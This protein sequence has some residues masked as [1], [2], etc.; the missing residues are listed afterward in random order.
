[1]YNGIGLAQTTIDRILVVRRGPVT[2][3]DTIYQV[4][5]SDTFI[6]VTDSASQTYFISAWVCSGS[7]DTYANLSVLRCDKEGKPK[8]ALSVRMSN[9]LTLENN[10]ET[11]DYKVYKDNPE[12]ENV[13]P[14]LA[15]FSF[16]L[17]SDGTPICGISGDPVIA[18]DDN[19]P[20]PNNRLTFYRV[21]FAFTVGESIATD[22]MGL[23]I[24]PENQDKIVIL[25]T[26]SVEDNDN[27]NQTTV[28]FDGVKLEKA[29]FDG[30]DRPTTYHK[31]TT[32]VSPS[33]SLDLSGKHKHYEW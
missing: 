18:K 20:D 25:L 26:Q 15:T 23:S 2:P 3:G 9:D 28:Y 32:L 31:D 10:L 27:P 16:T 17:K 8:A 22:S 1:M 6:D 12:Y 19:D 33:Q 5:A 4:I 24:E 30:Q 29:L 7:P 11:A 14:S 21:Y 13:G